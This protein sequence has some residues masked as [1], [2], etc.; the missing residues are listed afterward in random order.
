MSAADESPSSLDDSR[1]ST[2]ESP[3]PIRRP[4]E[5][6]MGQIYRVIYSN[7]VGWFFASGRTGVHR[8][9]LGV[10]AARSSPV[11]TRS[12]G[13]VKNELQDR[14]EG[15]RKSNSQEIGVYRAHP[16]RFRG[17]Y[18]DSAFM[19]PFDSQIVVTRSTKSVVRFGKS[20]EFISSM[21]VSETCWT[22]SRS[23]E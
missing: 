6:Y 13:P 3:D 8:Y 16:R 5:N 14:T 22:N 9:F 20:S 23:N 7:S 19:V 11:S 18:G 4:S 2:P 10:S 12:S 1:V 21:G 15:W 17:R